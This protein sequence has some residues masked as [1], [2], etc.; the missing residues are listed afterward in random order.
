MSKT[1]QNEVKPSKI[2]QDR[3]QNERLR[4]WLWKRGKTKKNKA[5]SFWNKAKE[6]EYNRSST[7]EDLPLLIRTP[8]FIFNFSLRFTSFDHSEKGAKQKQKQ[9]QKQ[10]VMAGWDLIFLYLDVLLW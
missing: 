9:K 10:K 8:F 4:Q 6:N 1:K 2:V 5:S 7:N 3:R